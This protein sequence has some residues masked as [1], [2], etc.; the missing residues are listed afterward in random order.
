MVMKRS[1]SEQPDELR[2]QHPGSPSRQL[3]ATSHLTLTDSR[4]AT[5]TPV[6]NSHDGTTDDSTMEDL[7]NEGVH[8]LGHGVKELVVAINQ[9]Q[10]LG[11]EDVSGPTPKVAVIGDQSAGKSSVIEA[12]SGIQ[13]P[14]SDGC[15][16]RCPLQ[17]TLTTDDEPGSNWH[18]KVSL[19]KNYVYSNSEAASGGMASH[20]F[21]PWCEFQP[22]RIDFASTSDKSE[23]REI[24][25]QAQMLTV[26]PQLGPLT[27]NAP[28]LQGLRPQVA[29]SPNVVHIEITGPELPTLSFYD[30]P[31]V[32]TQTERAEDAFYVEFVERLLYKYIAEDIHDGQV[33][34]K[35]STLVLLAVSMEVDRATCS[36]AKLVSKWGAEDRCVGVMTKP[37]RRPDGDSAKVWEKM[38]RGDIYRLGHGYYVTK[39]PSQAELN[40]GVGHDAARQ[41]E[42]QYFEHSTPWSTQL[43]SFQER[44]GVENLQAALSQELARMALNSFPLIHERVQL[45]LERIDEELS[46]M[47]EP[48]V[49]NAIHTVLDRLSVL[50]ATIS[51]RMDGEFAHNDFRL[52]FKQVR[53]RFKETIAAQRPKII[54]STNHDVVSAQRLLRSLS[55]HNTPTKRD[56]P[57]TIDSSDEES[58][59]MQ[60]TPTKRRKA[61]KTEPGVP[62]TPKR[63]RNVPKSRTAMDLDDIR[64]ALDSLST[65]DYAGEIEPKALNQL[66]KETLAQ[67]DIPMSAFLDE[68]EKALKEAIK[69][70]VDE[71]LYAWKSSALYTQTLDIVDKYL[72][73]QMHE[74]RHTYAPRMLYLERL[75]PMTE[76][77]ALLEGFVK[78]ELDVLQNARYEARANVFFDQMAN[79]GGKR[80]EPEERKK[81][82]LN[83][84]QLKRDLGPDPYAREI[85]AMSRIRGYYSVASM[86]FVDNLCQAAQGDVLEKLKTGLHDELLTVL[87]L[88]ENNAHANCVQ[89]LAED[90]Q[91]ELRRVE[92]RDKRSKLCEAMTC[93][94]ELDAKYKTATASSASTLT[95]TSYRNV[96]PCQPSAESVPEDDAM[97]EA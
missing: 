21:W 14:R 83:D 71:A 7:D 25:S 18:C 31:G 74:L 95:R 90:W 50:T 23:I 55:I 22:S 78:N 87:G 10:Q 35:N 20:P 89:L 16:T 81:K 66:R 72:G 15:C 5:E 58:V 30:L 97:D 34:M 28:Q 59:P 32:F 93:L 75:K 26:N 46:Q 43:A 92:L 79:S 70:T 42:R 69:I 36:A 8:R 57:I 38:L 84:V 51:K 77:T 80:V 61:E 76:A 53:C 82:I 86:R 45:R 44:F 54:P 27:Y 2:S 39:N 52:N 85:E 41:L 60:P 12:I 1:E 4:S 49:A 19:L 48:P 91:R 37:D 68:L 47:P 33:V 6:I 94:H 40:Q 29:F 64:K 88:A 56:A 17:I 9:L 13:V 24:I 67:W 73:M 3:R 96:T 11:I 65:S 63:R 62:E